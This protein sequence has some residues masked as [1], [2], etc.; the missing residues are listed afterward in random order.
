MPSAGIVA[1]F[2]FLAIDQKQRVS[3]FG[4]RPDSLVHIHKQAA[5]RAG[6]KVNDVAEHSL[7]PPECSGI[8]DPAPVW[9]QAGLENAGQV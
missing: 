4:L 7:R 5:A 3:P 9:P 8:P 6:L 1:G 2:V